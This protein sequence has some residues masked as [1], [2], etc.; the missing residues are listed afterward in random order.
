MG[1]RNLFGDKEKRKE[2]ERRKGGKEEGRKE[3][4]EQ[5]RAAG[6]GGAE[7]GPSRAGAAECWREEPLHPASGR[8]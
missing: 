7:K 1:K 4:R 2:E 8:P 6:R 5:S 3:G